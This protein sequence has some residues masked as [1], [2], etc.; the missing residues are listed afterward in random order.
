M[1][2]VPV[3]AMILI[4]GIGEDRDSDKTKAFKKAKIDYYFQLT[5]GTKVTS[6]A[7]LGTMLSNAQGDAEERSVKYKQLELDATKFKDKKEEKKK[8]KE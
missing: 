8:E 5:Y 1:N 3:S 4:F 6:Q 7:A 2:K